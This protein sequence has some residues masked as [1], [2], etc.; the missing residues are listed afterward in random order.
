MRHTRFAASLLLA[1]PLLSH[2]ADVTLTLQGRIISTPNLFDNGMVA[3]DPRLTAADRAAATAALSAFA[4]EQDVTV[5][6]SFNTDS[7]RASPQTPFGLDIPPEQADTVVGYR[8]VGDETA[9]SNI[10]T[11]ITVSDAGLNYS[12]TAPA[13]GGSRFLQTTQLNINNPDSGTY[14]SIQMGDDVARGLTFP[15]QPLTERRYD[16]IVGYILQSGQDWQDADLLHMLSS[17][18]YSGAV[19]PEGRI[20]TY[21]PGC[22]LNGGACGYVD[23]SIL[24]TTLTVH[25]AVPE[26]STWATMGL[27]LVGLMG[28]TGARNRRQFNALQR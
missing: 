7:L 27:G 15:R 26:P 12:N 5:S 3:A 13:N 18:N 8:F 20:Y 9:S 11:N 19:N 23:F 24:N 21:D 17:Y 4:L 2:A 10:T 25:A 22:A 6:Y 1:L 16:T 28:L 14:L